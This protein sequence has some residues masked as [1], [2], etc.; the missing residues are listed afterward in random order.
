MP[1]LER[2]LAEKY[3]SDPDLKCPKCEEIYD[4]SNRP[5]LLC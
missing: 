3:M 2:K 1:E 4:C 5:V